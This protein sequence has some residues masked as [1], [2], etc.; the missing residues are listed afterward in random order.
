MTRRRG[1]RPGTTTT[2]EQIRTAAREH[3]AEHG[4]DRTSIRA[5]AAR[6]GVDPALVHHFYPTKK[7]LFTAA[8]QQPCQYGE[9]NPAVVARPLSEDALR[10]VLTSWDTRG[11]PDHILALTKASVV[12]PHAAD[13]LRDLIITDLL[14]PP[15]ATTHNGPDLGP[16]LLG[17][18]LMGIAFN[19]YVLKVGTLANTSTAD[20][21]AALSALAHDLL[22][23]RPGQQLGALAEH[24]GQGS[25]SRRR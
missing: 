11:V 8:V 12:E 17:A 7:Q 6:A 14:G 5:V 3:F 15:H 24:G 20:L 22:E 19:R 2:R 21:A 9:P 13:I 10:V 1:R 4:Y 25:N 23:R 18:L 16:A